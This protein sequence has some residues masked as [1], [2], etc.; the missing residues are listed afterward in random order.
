LLEILSGISMCLSIRVM[1]GFER[2]VSS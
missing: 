2:C 1:G